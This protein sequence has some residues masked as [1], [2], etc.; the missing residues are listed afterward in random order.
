M[1]SDI[2]ISQCMIVKNEEKNIKKAL[3]WAKNI[4][5]E[6][7]VVDTGST[8]HT[9]EIA[10][11]LGA[12]VYSFDWIDDFSA[13]RNFAV[14]KAS[15]EWI[16]FLDADEYFTQENA[17]K[18]IHYLK[19]IEKVPK[20]KS[21]NI[22]RCSLLHLED[23]G[24]I[25]SI[26]LQDRVF[27]NLPGL[28]YQNRIHEN[29]VFSGDGANIIVDASQELSIIHTG[30][31]ASVYR[32]TNKSDRNIRM[33]ETEVSLN[34]DNDNAW[35]Y[36]SDSLLS[37]G[38][39][40]AARNACI[41][42][43]E[44]PASK[45]SVTRKNAVFSNLI[46]I[47]TLEAYEDAEV[48]IRHYYE[49]FL[50]TGNNFPDI[51][52][53]I[54]LWMYRQKKHSL[55]IDWL[56][57]ALYLLDRYDKNTPL[58]LSGDLE[59]VYLSLF[60]SSLEISDRERTL[61]YAVL[62]LRLNNRNEMAIQTLLCLLLDEKALPANVQSVYNFLGKLY[63]LNR[64]NDIGFLLRQARLTGFPELEKTILTAAGESARN[65]ESQPPS[66]PF[67]ARP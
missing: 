35:S 4:A 14:S 32:D 60:L 24:K 39:V 28:R 48:Q 6:Q 3:S 13:A 2:R 34:P 59:N 53:W 65:S 57:K 27:R 63:D 54:G 40:Q 45:I 46:K 31:A 21:P 23:D 64:P 11:N 38:H 49:M 61:K 52:Y 56:E 36:L 17:L 16:A 25:C 26:S 41:K 15:G 20:E 29:L 43:I 33:L 18:L 51:E 8:D 22:I 66:P 7:I 44:H 12:V 42:V 1:I 50:K 47:L 58:V 19:Q 10:R 30:Y 9:I 37:G 67:P 5:F 62:A 55:S